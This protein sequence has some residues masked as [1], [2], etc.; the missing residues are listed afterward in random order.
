SSISP[1]CANRATASAKLAGPVSSSATSAA[2]AGA[3][4]GSGSGSGATRSAAAPE[5]EDGPAG[6]QPDEAREAD[7]CGARYPP[8][9][10][11]GL[12]PAAD[13]PPGDTAGGGSGRATGAGAAADG[14]AAEGAPPV[15]EPT[16]SP[17]P[18]RPPPG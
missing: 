4:S 14:P 17:S 9:T 7:G 11:D 18:E 15:T 3:G 1:C 16:G 2:A 6:A 5:W 12:C 10:A 13:D 8:C